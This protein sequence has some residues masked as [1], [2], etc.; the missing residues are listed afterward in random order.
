MSRVNDLL[1]KLIQTPMVPTVVKQSS[2]EDSIPLTKR[3]ELNTF[4]MTR[5]FKKG[6]A[7]HDESDGMVDAVLS[8]AAK[9]ENIPDLNLVEKGQVVVSYTGGPVQISEDIHLQIEELTFEQDSEKVEKVSLTLMSEKLTSNELAQFVRKLYETHLE[10]LKN[11]LKNAT[12]YFEYKPKDLNVN[13]Q[14]GQGLDERRN[15]KRAMIQSSPKQLS[16][17]MSPFYSNKRFENIYGQDVRDIE[18]RVNFFLEN[19]AWYD[20]KGIPYQ[21]S[22]LFSG[23][24]GAGK[25]SVIRAIA[26]KTKR[27]IV[28]VNFANINTATQLKN[29]FFSDRIQVVTDATTPQTYFI[30]INQRLYVLEE[31]DALGDIVKQRTDSSRVRGDGIPDE[32]TLGEIL[33]VLDGTIE[34]PGRMIIMTTNHPEVLDRALIRPGRVDLKVHFGKASRELIAEMFRGYRDHEMDPEALEKIPDRTKSPAEVSQILFK[35]FGNPDEC[36]LKD[37]V[38]PEP[39]SK[40]LMEKT[41]TKPIL[42]LPL[43]KA[44]KVSDELII[45]GFDILTPKLKEEVLSKP[46]L[47]EQIEVIYSI[48]SQSGLYNRMS[49][50]N[51]TEL[52]LNGYDALGETHKRTVNLELMHSNGKITQTVL[53]IVNPD[54]LHGDGDEIVG[55]SSGD[56]S[57][58]NYLP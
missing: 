30:P 20:K 1:L 48:M 39:E 23:I 37:L 36:V 2:I 26:N 43:S 27:H 35:H 33:A 31:L 15:Y 8:F 41:E 49:S 10:E 13:L 55:Y 40:E 54:L 16:F 58:D 52:R 44:P 9:L 50:S 57:E 24:S 45:H 38:E 53:N 22:M 28:N 46:T 7:S 29:M 4:F 56:G 25:T 17:S 12:Y 5:F 42:G 3:H 34:V 47:P 21:L 51:L 32:L 11:S 6:E 14:Y 18:Q 19:R